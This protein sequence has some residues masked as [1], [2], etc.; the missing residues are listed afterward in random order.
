MAQPFSVAIAPTSVRPAH[1]MIL[2]LLKRE[3]L[4]LLAKLVSHSIQENVTANA[5]RTPT[6]MPKGNVSFV[7]P[8]ANLALAPP[9]QNAEDVNLDTLLTLQI[10]FLA[11]L[12]PKCKKNKTPKKN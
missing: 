7:I 4:V 12:N 6:L 11:Y 3:S 10:K 9:T 1:S 2:L 5:N 8:H